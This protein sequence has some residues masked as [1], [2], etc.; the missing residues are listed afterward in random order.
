VTVIQ[1]VI[2]STFQEA[3]GKANSAG[4]ILN[5]AAGFSASDVDIFYA[6]F[7]EIFSYFTHFLSRYFPHILSRY[8]P[9]FFVEIFSEFFVEI[10]FALYIC[11]DI[12]RILAKHFPNFLPE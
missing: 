6:D 9:N 12:F 5:Y 4:Q 2:E 3:A 7:F 1:N 11:R 8:I 10:F